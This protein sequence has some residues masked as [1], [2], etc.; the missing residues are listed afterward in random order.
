MNGTKEFQYG[1]MTHRKVVYISIGLVLCIVSLIADVLIGSSGMKPGEVWQVL[2]HPSSVTQALKAIVWDIRLPIAFMALVVGASLGISGAAMQTILGNPLAS[3]YTL[4]LSAGAGFGASFALVVGLGS[5]PV[6]GNIAVSLCAF[7][8]ALLACCGIYLI[9]KK[10]DFSTGTMVLAGI[11][12][13]FF[14]QAGQ[15]F[16]QYIASTEALSGVVFWTFGSL[17][18]ASWPKVLTVLVVFLAVF[19]VFYGN[20]WKM[21][22][23]TMGEERA[24]VL[25]VNV[26]NLRL[27][28]F[29]LISLLTATAVSFVGCIGFV[30]IVA[31]HISRIF[32]GEDQ[33][34][35]LPMSAVIGALL[36]SCANIAAKSII[37]GAVFPIGILTSLIGVPVFFALI[38]KKR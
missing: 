19:I 29:V 23:I 3:P 18:K 33:R 24:K 2:I 4:G 27:L 14:F 35:Y 28:T 16:M 26:K 13:V 17:S 34:Y 36:L 12:M 11:G 38:I 30:G 32:L 8:C 6:A 9:S 25:G 10:K 22:A 1:S 37:P 15:S 21:T 5:L 20:S 7:I 31:P